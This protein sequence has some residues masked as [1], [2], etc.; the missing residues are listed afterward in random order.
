MT[1]QYQKDRAAFEA[2][3]QRQRN[4]NLLREWLTHHH[5]DIPVCTAV[6]NIFREYMDFEDPLTVEDFEF[7]LGN[8]GSMIGRQRI[9]SEAETKAALIDKIVELTSK[10]GKSAGTTFKLAVSGGRLL[11]WSIPLLATWSVPQ[12]TELLNEIVRKRTL[13]TQSSSELH[14]IVESARPNYG[15]PQLPKQIV[16]P[17]TVRAVP[18]DAA[19][20]RNLGVYDLKKLI[21]L[22]GGQQVNTRLAGKD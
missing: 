22:Y 8:L 13:V 2:S 5:P 20:I 4:V 1:T 17:G 7:A 14:Q 18:L 21:R 9:P 10:D 12:L 16:R 11:Q 19:Y 6:E 3:E 15:Y